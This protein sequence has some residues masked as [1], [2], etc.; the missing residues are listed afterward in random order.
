MTTRTKGNAK[1]IYQLLFIIFPTKQLW[2]IRKIFSNVRLRKNR[3]LHWETRSLQI[4]AESPVESWS[5][6]QGSRGKLVSGDLG[7]QRTLGN[8][9][10]DVSL[11]NSSSLLQHHVI[12]VVIVVVVGLWMLTGQVFPQRCL[13]GEL[14]VAPGAR[15][16]DTSGRRRM[17]SVGQSWFMPA[18]VRGQI[19]R[20][21][22]SLVAFW[23][24]VLDVGYPGAPVL[25]QLE[26]VLV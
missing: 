22:E 10:N 13:P 18:S 19:R 20:T 25:G 12:V 4:K 5:S 7:V 9:L 6:G 23:T 26:R 14:R 21:R 16:L 24:S 1:I 8:H 3:A 17:F 11:T 15:Y 2:K